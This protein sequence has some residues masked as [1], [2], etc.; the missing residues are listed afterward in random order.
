M[1]NKQAQPA[2]T[3]STNHQTK[4]PNL[5]QTQQLTNKQAVTQLPKQN[6][7]TNKPSSK[8]T[9]QATNKTQ[10]NTNKVK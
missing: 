4:Q 10:N 9:I 1:E 3:K 7:Q 5:N 2:N 8:S 6:Q